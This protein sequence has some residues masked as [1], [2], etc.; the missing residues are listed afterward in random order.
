MSYAYRVTPT[1]PPGT[2]KTNE[3]GT[4]WPAPSPLG[5]GAVLVVWAAERRDGSV[6]SEY[7]AHRCSDYPDGLA[8]ALHAARKLYKQVVKRKSTYSASIAV[9]LD[10]TDY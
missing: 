7:F 6:A 5:G 2:Y 10:S 9:T 3:I 4:E 1:L 8:G